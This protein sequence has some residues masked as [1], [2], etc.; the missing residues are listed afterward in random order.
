MKKPYIP[1]LNKPGNPLKYEKGNRSARTTTSRIFPFLT[2]LFSVF[3]K[4]T[5]LFTFRFH[6]RAFFFHGGVSKNRFLY[7]FDFTVLVFFK[8]EVSLSPDF[9]LV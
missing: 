9:L 1:E 2:D 5:S 3:G 6:R 8:R 7:S 4:H